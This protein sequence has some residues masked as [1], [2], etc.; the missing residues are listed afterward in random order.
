MTEHDGRLDPAVLKLAAI[1]VVGALAPL[2]D[3]TIVNV[4]LRTLSRDLDTSLATVQWVSS[5]YLLALV[6]AVPI[7]G[8][9]Q[10]RYGSKRVWLAALVLFLAGSLLSGVAWSIGALI[11]FRVVQGLGGGLM[12]PTLQTMLMRAAGGPRIGKLMAVITLPIL[13]GP[14][15][16]PVVGG[17]IL[18][19]VSWRWIFYVNV[20][21]CVAA[22]VLAWWGL[23]S[24]KPDG[25]TSHLDRLG[26][27]ILSP[28]LA[29]LIYGL[30]QVG[31]QGGFEHPQVLA[32]L[33][34]GTLLM[35]GFLAH[36]HHTAQ[37]LIDLRLFRTRSF[38]ASS[39]LL[40]ASG[41]ALFGSMLLLPIYFQQARGET[42]VA[43]GLLLAP[44][45]VG[46]LLARPMGA[47]ADRTGPRPVIVTGLTLTV[48]ATVAFAFAGP[49]A[50]GPLL[51]TALVALGFGLS[52]T[53]MGVMV[54]AYRDLPSEQI[55]SASST[56]RIV[57]Q[58]G[59][60]FGAAVLAVVLQHQLGVHPGA[61][62]VD[63]AFQNTFLWLA[64]LAVVAFVPAALLPR[65]LRRPEDEAGPSAGSERAAGVR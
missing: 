44:Q 20:P 59:G 39:A 65:H 42:L 2:L 52:S 12:L 27:L 17:L 9:A 35:V 1:L 21:I 24:D 48:L 51:A 49:Y 13:L 16:G 6:V 36:A 41:L 8:W 30:S 64:G 19:Q 58:L 10:E 32:P 47:L 55:P 26:L 3:S 38:A 5:G 61:A 40:F 56:T 43:T 29:C 63:T 4:A 22:V 54:G 23:P 62:G 15:L 14:I 28:A 7:T 50:G 60:A 11:T 57:Q 34:A 25:R 31:D 18:G 53:N 33:A 37:P 46:S 45:G